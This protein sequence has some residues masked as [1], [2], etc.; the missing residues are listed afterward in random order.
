MQPHVAHRDLKPVRFL[1]SPLGPQIHLSTGQYYILITKQGRACLAD[2]GLTSTFDQDTQ[3]RTA[4]DQRVMGGSLNYM[5]PELHKAANN[6]RKRKVNQRACD[7]YALGCTIYAAYTG[8]S[9]FNGDSVLDVAIKVTCG[10]RPSLP[11][12]G[13]SWKTFGVLTH[14]SAS[15]LGEHSP[16]WS[17]KR[18]VRA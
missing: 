10:Q 2:F 6:E 17:I 9:P 8:S 4:T 16:G 3:F 11:T 7:M 18:L 1:L 13:A 15:R 12:C 5:A 14:L